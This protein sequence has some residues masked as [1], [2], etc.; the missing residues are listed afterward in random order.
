MRKIAVVSVIG[1]CLTVLIIA[2]FP[3]LGDA[4]VIYG[5][6]ERLTGFVR[7]V[8]GP[9]KCLQLEIPISWNQDGPIG[10]IGPTG[11]AGPQGPTGA[12]GPAGATGATGATG[13]QGP[14]GPAGSTG[15]MGPAGPTSLTA[16]T[17][18][19][20]T[21]YDGEAS[22]LNITVAANGTVMITCP[23]PG[24]T[25]KKVFLTSAL[26]SGNLGG[27]AGADMLCQNLAITAG[28]SGT[29]KA[30][31]SDSN[32]S[33]YSRFTHPTQN[34]VRV[35]GVLVAIGWQGI[36]SGII[37]NPINVTEIGTIVNDNTNGAWTNTM[38]TGLAWT[39][40]ANGTCT[41]WTSENTSQNTEVILGSNMHTDYGWTWGFYSFSCQ[42]HY[43][44]Y[45]FEQ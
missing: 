22:V 40:S 17:G 7:I 26:Y 3:R 33:P 30:W 1:I 12:Q 14:Q 41:D 37:Q 23:S 5:C 15:P 43:R 19:A 31:L 20:C 45:C 2:G 44:L 21:A 8:S 29:F 18:T 34:Y 36:T 4:A 10:P 25:S 6:Q 42:A 32:Q 16:L 24:Q 28:L 38:D 39:A 9:G 27:L 35:D 11:S 13:S